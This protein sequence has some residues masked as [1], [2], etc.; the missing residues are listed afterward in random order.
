MY[1]LADPPRTSSEAFETLNRIFGS[2]EFSAS[3]ASEVLEETL[4]MTSSEA[5]SALNR[6]I[7]SDA[8]EEV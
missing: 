2:E 8:I 7:R 5:R 3:E 4:D 6:L 1:V